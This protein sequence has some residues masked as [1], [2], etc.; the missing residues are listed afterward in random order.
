MPPRGHP[1]NR[2]RASPDG[3]ASS[4]NLFDGVA[5]CPSSRSSPGST[6]CFP[7]L[8]LPNPCATPRLKLRGVMG[9][10]CDAA[11]WPVK[12]ANTLIPRTNRS[13]SSLIT[14]R[15]SWKPRPHPSRLEPKHP[16]PPCAEIPRR[17]RVL[18]RDDTGVERS[19][20]DGP[21]GLQ[22]T[23]AEVLAKQDRAHTTGP[24]VPS[25][26][27]RRPTSI[28]RFQPIGSTAK[29]PQPGQP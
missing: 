14:A 6:A 21:R 27:K 10:Q 23:E 11:P 4:S 26:S 3:S 12:P 28:D 7:A 20:Q 2:W 9:P 25:R 29:T 19:A 1:W 8:P 13:P 24:T 17:R 18:R 5:P 16:T 15:P 22:G